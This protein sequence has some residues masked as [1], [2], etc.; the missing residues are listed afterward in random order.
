MAAAGA[1]HCVMEVSSHGLA[2]GRTDGCR[3]RAA[4]FTNL[5]PEHLDFHKTLE[6]YKQAKWRLFGEILAR[7]PK[8]KHTAVLNLDD[9]VGKEWSREL[10][11]SSVTFSLWD[12][13]ADVRAEDADFSLEGIR[14]RVYAD[15]EGFDVESPLIGEHNEEIYIGELGFSKGQLTALRARGVI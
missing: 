15:G 4:A 9:P 12:S 6:D 14:A 1:S 3:F 8:K 7:S 11:G 13:R 2:L 5:Q 10:A